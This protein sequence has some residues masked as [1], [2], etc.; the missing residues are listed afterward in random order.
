MADDVSFSVVDTRKIGPVDDTINN[1]W[2][3]V[4][5]RQDKPWRTIFNRRQIWCDQI[6]TKSLGTV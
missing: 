4:L 2:I 5:Y 6:S 1:S 3:S